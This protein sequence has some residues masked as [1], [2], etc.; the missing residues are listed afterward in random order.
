MWICVCSL[1]CPFSDPQGVSLLSIHRVEGFQ[2]K[3]KTNSCHAFMKRLIMYGKLEHGFN[4]P[5]LVCL[6][7]FLLVITLVVSGLCQAAMI[8]QERKDREGEWLSLWGSL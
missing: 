8:S 2:H 4:T 3:G 5:P 1:A 6:S 7:V